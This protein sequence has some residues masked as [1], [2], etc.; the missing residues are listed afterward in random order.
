[1]ATLDFGICISISDII[2]N[3]ADDI[4][5]LKNIII[6][7]FKVLS[8]VTVPIFVSAYLYNECSDKGIEIYSFEKAL[9]EFLDKYSYNTF[10]FTVEKEKCRV[11]MGYLDG[12][13]TIN[14]N[15]AYALFRQ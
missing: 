4:E 11:Y 1:M 9:K 6:N 10:L 12:S 7:S 14:I 3:N 5:R 15:I 2:K 8:P 13:I